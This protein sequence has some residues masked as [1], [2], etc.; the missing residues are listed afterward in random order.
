MGE[1]LIRD[2]GVTR[3][4]GAADL[5]AVNLREGWANPETAHNWN[6]GYDASLLLKL[7][8]SPDFPCVLIIEAKPYLAPGLIRQDVTF[9][10]NGLRLGFWRLDKPALAVLEVGI[11]PEYW[12]KRPGEALGLCAWHLP[13]SAR[14]SDVSGAGDER[15][16]GLCFQ[17]L[18][19]SRRPAP[20]R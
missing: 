14:P 8:T 19:L 15:L 13:D 7:E 3:F 12:L 1:L 10:F 2:F 5:G 16:L 17:T 11:E 18:T 4:F 9:Y 20:R 6:E